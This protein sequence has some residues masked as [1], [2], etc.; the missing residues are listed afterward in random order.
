[1]LDQLYVQHQEVKVAV[2]DE[3]P[4]TESE[5]KAYL[6]MLSYAID[7][8]SEYMVAHTI[9]TT[10]V[11]TTLAALCDYHPTEIEKVYYGALLHDIGKVAIPVTILDFPGR[12]SP[13]DMA[14]MQS[15]VTYSMK[16]LHGV[17][18]EEIEHIAV[19]HH[20]KLNGK[21]YPLGL[22]EEALTT[23]ERIVAIADIIS[24]L[25]G[26]RSYKEA[27]DLE[28]IKEI[29]QEMA[30]GQYLDDRIVQIACDNLPHILQTVKRDCTPVIAMYQEIRRDY[31]HRIAQLDR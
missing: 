24:A 10:S 8:R 20:E 28:K 16:I 7:F 17:V 6:H 4:F 21:G 5:G 27:Y 3:I 30:E 12:L 29:L 23:S 31:E 2:F 22:K 14:V 26:K 1:M 15:H 9:T 13:Q 11:S 18:D 19:R 25:I